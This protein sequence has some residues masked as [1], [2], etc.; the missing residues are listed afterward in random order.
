LGIFIGDVT[1]HGVPAAL[2]L[3]LVRSVTNQACR[4]HGMCPGKYI[5]MINNE[6][7]R[8]MPS[9]YLTALYG[10]F[11]KHPDSVTFTFARGG[12]Q[13]PILCQRGSNNVEF[14]KSRGK[15]LGWQE[16][17]LF[18]DVTLTLHPGDRLFLYTDG[19]PDKVNPEGRMLDA[20]DDFI[21]LFRDPDRMTLS[22]ML[23]SIIDRTMRFRDGAPI[24]DDIV[25]IGIEVH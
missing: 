22:G 21:N 15:L 13:Y 25:L 1:G 24:V 19:I 6:V 10:V 2:F 8:G 18:G 3:S 17:T 11:R 4:R 5:E 7:F 9:Y 16:N 14:V 12:H 23:D 20:E